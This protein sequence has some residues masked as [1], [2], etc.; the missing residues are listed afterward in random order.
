MCNRFGGEVAGDG[1]FIYNTGKSAAKMMTLGIAVDCSGYHI[2]LNAVAPSMV[3]TGLHV[4]GGMMR[5][6]I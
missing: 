2:N 1:S 5:T 6:R 4:D 3:L